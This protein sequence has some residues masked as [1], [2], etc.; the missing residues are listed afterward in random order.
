MRWGIAL[1]LG[2]I[3]CGHYEAAGAYELGYGGG[4]ECADA[5]CAEVEAHLDVI[6][7]EWGG[8]CGTVMM[9]EQSALIG[10]GNRA[11]PTLVRELGAESHV[12]ARV[13]ARTLVRLGHAS[14][15]VSWCGNNLGA[16]T[17]AFVCANA[18]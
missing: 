4:V 14:E 18:R 7:G 2:A 8:W 16:E 11:V 9:T 17:F 6:R 5:D 3:G 10:M 12:H 15:I 13:A 1:T